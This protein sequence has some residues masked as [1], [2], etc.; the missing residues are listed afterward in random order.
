MRTQRVCLL[1]AAVGQESGQG[2]LK[3]R[4]TSGEIDSVAQKPPD[5]EARF[6]FVLVH[7]QWLRAGRGKVTRNSASETEIAGRCLG[8][9]EPFNAKI[10][11]RTK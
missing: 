3:L 7:T 5:N 6:G 1:I 11:Q 4:D 8:G 10:R 2:S 9:V